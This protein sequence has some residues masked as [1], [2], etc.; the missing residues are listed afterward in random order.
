MEE[1]LKIV[2]QETEL[3]PVRTSEEF[4]GQDRFVAVFLTSYPTDQTRNF[5]C[6]NCGKLLFQYEAEV[7]MI[8]DGPDKPRDRA[9]FEVLCNR[10]RVIYR[11]IVI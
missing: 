2:I 10:C 1:H 5:R 11:L 6:L 3:V 7:V 4:T 8:I 9:S